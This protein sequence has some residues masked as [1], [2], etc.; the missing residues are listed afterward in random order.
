MQLPL[1]PVA[2]AAAVLDAA[3]QTSAPASPAFAESASGSS[4]LA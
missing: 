1:P 2:A 3:L 4:G